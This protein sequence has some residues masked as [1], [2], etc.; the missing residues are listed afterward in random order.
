MRTL[1]AIGVLGFASAASGQVGPTPTSVHAATATALHNPVCRA[2]QPFYWEIGDASGTLVSAS[3]GSPAVL[4]STNMNVA[5]S[6]KWLYGGYV[7]QLR[8]SAANLTAQDITF[9]TMTS[10]YTNIGNNDHP[11]GTCP[12]TDDPDTVNVC[13]AR[14]NPADG[15]PYSYQDPST[16]GFFDYDGGHYENHAS[17]YTGI[18]D[19]QTQALGKAIGNRLGPNVI[20]TYSQ[21]LLPGGA[22]MTPASF[23]T[24]LRN[25]VS[26][27]L[28]MLGALG[29]FPVCTLASGTC[30]A[31][32]SP[33]T[34]NWHFS[35]GHWV[36]DDPVQNDDGAFSAAG[37]EGF[38][39]WI[40][41]ST[42]YYGLIARAKTGS[43]QQGLQSVNCGQLVRFAWD[44]GVTQLK[45]TRSAK[46]ITSD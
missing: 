19:T 9:L 5:S 1:A 29:A 31:L 11:A 7:V 35:I 32:N 8:G 23:A 45:K 33:F 2:A 22:N 27:D 13:L 37:G 21:P 16:I 41:A 18:G 36:E 34:Y 12:T 40:E 15:L 38:Y 39:P 28:A 42:V 4:S 26:G 24:F 17:L 46:T 43:G 30:T 25:I 3:V 14:L 20:L 6:A 44:T 10:G